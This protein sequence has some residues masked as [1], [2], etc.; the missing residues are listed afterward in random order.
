MAEHYC[1]GTYDSGSDDESGSEHV[2]VNQDAGVQQVDAPRELF[3]RSELAPEC[4]DWGI[5]LQ[6]CQRLQNSTNSKD[7][8]LWNYHS[9]CLVRCI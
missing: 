7:A 8:H 3:P 2:N 1:S 9:S 6:H 5:Y 4:K